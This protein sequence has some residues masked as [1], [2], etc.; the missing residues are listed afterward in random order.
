MVGSRAKEMFDV[1]ATNKDKIESAVG[2]SLNWN[3]GNSLKHSRVWIVDDTIGLDNEADW[4]RM[5]EFHAKWV[6]KFCDVIVP[7]LREYVAG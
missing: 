5:A 7:L 6:K 2:H 1:L 4:V 3:R